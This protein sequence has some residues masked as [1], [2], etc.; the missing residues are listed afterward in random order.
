MNASQV[1]KLLK[2]AR[3][4]GLS[5]S[6]ALN[7][8]RILEAAGL[9]PGQDEPVSIRERTAPAARSESLSQTVTA[10]RTAPVSDEPPVYNAAE[11]A[12]GLDRNADFR[13]LVR[14]MENLLG[15]VLSSSDMQLIFAMYD[16]RGLPPGVILL[17]VHHCI[18]ETKARL[19]PDRTP[20]LRQIDKEAAYWEKRGLFTE[21]LAEQ[22]IAGREESRSLTRQYMQK[23]QIGGREP[24]ATETKYLDDWAQKKFHP[25]VIYKAYDITVVKTGKMT[26]KYCDSILRSWHEQGWHTLSDMAAPPP[27]AVPPAQPEDSMDK[28]LKYLRGEP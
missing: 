6:D 5:E 1:E 4:L 22:F 11:L 13:A 15:K 16:W 14:E 19:G 17:L 2:T 7:A 18:A 25:D 20:T 28:M 3:R 10:A 24:T 8:L 26:W 9:F 12:R 21:E 27:A 23:L